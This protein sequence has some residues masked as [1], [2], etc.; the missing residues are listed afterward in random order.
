[1]GPTLDS[2]TVTLISKLLLDHRTLFKYRDTKSP[3]CWGR[4][5]SKNLKSWVQYK[6]K[7]LNYLK[8][9][10]HQTYFFCDN[11]MN[12]ENT[13]AKLSFSFVKKVNLE[14]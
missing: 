9:L 3:F 8:S 6:K 11:S 7:I 14:S 10:I 13:V 4:I 5:R 2:L 1:M 12:N